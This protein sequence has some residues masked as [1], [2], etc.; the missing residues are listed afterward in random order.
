MTQQKDFDDFDDLLECAVNLDLAY[1]CKTGF[2][3]NQSHLIPSFYF[4]KVALASG[5]PKTLRDLYK[6][7]PIDREWFDQADFRG[8]L[9]TYL[10]EDDYKRILDLADKI[11]AEF[12]NKRIFY[13]YKDYINDV[14]EKQRYDLVWDDNA[15]KLFLLEL[16][17]AYQKEAGEQVLVEE[18]RY[19]E[20]NE[21]NSKNKKKKKEAAEKA[22]KALLVE[23]DEEEEAAKKGKKKNKKKNKKNATKPK[24]KQV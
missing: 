13:T 4:I 10:K 14:S 1:N 18:A 16:N 20:L 5:V 22:E 17:M 24:Q 12:M 15:T 11:G 3:K 8:Q 9:M 19:K 2:K 7:F 6:I 23:L 21:E